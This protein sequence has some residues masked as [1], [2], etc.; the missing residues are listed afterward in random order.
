M[1]PP[2]PFS[3][4]QLQYAVA[5]ADLGSFRRAAEACH[6]AQ[7]S[8]SAQIATLEEA[9][10]VVLF[11][12]GRSGVRVTAAGTAVLVRARSL[13]RDAADLGDEARRASD[14]L[15]GTLR[16]GV[17]PTL[18]PYLLPAL[19]PALRAALPAL[20]VRWREDKTEVLVRELR[21]GGLDAAILAEEA[22]ITGLSTTLLAVDGFVLALPPDH[23]LA[24]RPGPVAI[25]ALAEAT[26][27]LL[28]EGHCL[29]AQ[30]LPFCSRG[31]LRE[32]EFRATSLPTLV[33]MVAAGAGVTLL[34]RSSLATEAR[35]SDVALRT[36]IDAPSR[37]LV[38]VWRPGSVVAE[39]MARL[40]E[41]MAP[42]AR[43]V[44]G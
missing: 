5:V 4:R 7:P 41:V 22:E 17:I 14:P 35:R 38:L 28:D 24:Q 30:A 26:V 27:L 43:A 20:S 10:G 23:P 2:L 1:S 16:I 9:L 12:R 15:A 25:G 33:A 29:R 36:L 3:L 39:A 6:V 21:E 44:V 8:L 19:A 34:P 32:G 42:A 31:G 11:E 18:A 40:G 37:T 13:L